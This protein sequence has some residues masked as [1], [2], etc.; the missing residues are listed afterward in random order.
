MKKILIVEDDKAINNLIEIN[1]KIAEFLPF[2]AFD[3]NE[4]LKLI[5]RQKFDLI[6]LDVMIPHI[7]GFELA[8]LIN[9]YKIPII[10]LTAKNSIND[11]LKGF[12]LNC[13]DYVVKPFDMIE[14]MARIKALFNHYKLENTANVINIY[15]LEIN[16][17]KMVVKKNNEVV[18]LSLM[19]FKLLE[20]L[21]RNK[22][23]ALSREKI[24][25]EV[26]GYNYYGDSRTV[27][28][29]IQRLRS[30]LSLPNEI[31]TIYKVGYRLEVERWN[32][33]INLYWF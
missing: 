2:K 23:I 33:D 1:L 8:E 16:F 24:L 7:D 18:E 5:S 26:W 21:V 30:K 19:E 9:D 22:N 29:H 28:V 13:Y 6:L 25:I 15:D 27:D 12:N 17:D 31:K 11:K 14:L 10:F 4:A 3:G 20:M 32:L